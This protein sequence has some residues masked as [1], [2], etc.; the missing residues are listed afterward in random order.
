MP[1][2][3]NMSFPFCQVKPHVMIPDGNFPPFVCTWDLE[4]TWFSLREDKPHN[5]HQV[6]AFP[7]VSVSVW[8]TMVTQ[9]CVTRPSFGSLCHVIF[10]VEVTLAE[11]TE[12]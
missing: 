12:G 9:S 11:A 6:G 8:G 2:V 3:A 10:S 4:G 5:S 7:F 1:P